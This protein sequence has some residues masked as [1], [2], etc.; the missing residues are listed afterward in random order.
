[1]TITGN[2]ICPNCNRP[3][4]VI[5]GADTQECP[6]CKIVYHSSQFDIPV[7]YCPTEKQKNTIA[8]INK[9]LNLSLNPLT[10]NEAY[11]SIDR[12]LEPARERVNNV[13][14]CDD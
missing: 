2:K 3:M 8:F 1:M 6:Y 12:Y 14:L 11:R 13:M 10:K 5:S 4:I 9:T 7:L